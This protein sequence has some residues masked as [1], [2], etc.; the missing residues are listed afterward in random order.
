MS[1]PT[2]TSARAIVL[3]ISPASADPDGRD[4]GLATYLLTLTVMPDDE[5]PF[6]CRVRAALPVVSQWAV[7]VGAHVPV[8]IGPTRE[9]TV[10]TG[11]LRALFDLH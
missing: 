5:P 7:A 11:A 8:T 9:V 6:R 1:D 10:D 2:G 4:D 3:R